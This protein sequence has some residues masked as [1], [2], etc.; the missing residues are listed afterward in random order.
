MHQDWN[1]TLTMIRGSFIEKEMKRTNRN[2]L[3][4]SLLLLL[5]VGGY[6][7]LH[8]RYY[9]NFFR[10]PLRM[11][12]AALDR[13]KDPTKLDR[14]Y[15]RLTGDREVDTGYTEVETDSGAATVKANYVVIG[16]GSH[17]LIVKKNP[18]EKGPEYTGVLVEMP[19]DVKASILDAVTKES[20]DAARDFAP[21]M[22]DM[23]NFRSEGYWGLG[24]G[25]PI[26]LLALWLL[27]TVV[28]RTSSPATHPIFTMLARHGEIAD[29][30]QK[31]EADL[32]ADT[33]RFMLFRITPEWLLYQDIYAFKAM[34]LDEIVWVYKKVTKRR[35]NFIPVGKDHRLVLTDR[36]AMT[37]ETQ[38]V[39]EKKL[40]GFIKALV[41]R[42]PHAVVGYSEDLK[43]VQQK[44]A[45]SFAQEM[46][47]QRRLDRN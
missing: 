21:Y 2:L 27:R 16:A 47:E 5:G 35:V 32:K 39:R 37:I 4:T 33:E 41:P 6:F 45:A 42:L 25:I 18:G 28:M 9:E 24:V 43:K 20:P 7:V 17:Y 34:R 19:A 29:V 44:N 8:G 11:D 30:A 22:L 26:L 12:A 15:V 1:T 10:G 14:Y 46:W 40:D 36:Y 38:G 13:V 3:I 31:I 23:T